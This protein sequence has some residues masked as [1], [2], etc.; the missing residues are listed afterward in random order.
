[1]PTSPTTQEIT[2]SVVADIESKINQ[3]IPLLPKAFVRVIAK[4][5]AGIIVVL[6]KYAGFIFLQIFVATAS[7]KDT[8]VNGQ[9]INPLIF[10]G[11]LIGVGDPLPGIAAE[12]EVD[13]MVITQGGTL[14]AGKTNIIGSLNGVTYSLLTD[15]DLNADIVKGDFKAV[16]DPAGTSGIGS[17]GNLDTGDIVTFATPYGDV[18]SDAI[19]SSRLVD[20]A[21]SESK[22]SYEARVEER[23]GGRP[24]GGAGL[25]YVYWGRKVSG[26]INIYPYTGD[27]GEVDVYAEATPESSGNPDGIPTTAQLILVYDAIQNTEGGLALN[28]PIDSFVNVYGITRSGFTVDVFD[29]TGENIDT[30]KTDISEALTTFLLER[31]PYIDGVTSLPRKQDIKLDDIRSIVNDYATAANGSFSSVTLKFTV[32]GIPF[33]VYTLLEGEKA[34]LTIVNYPTTP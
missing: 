34:K 17:I 7:F 20:G 21:D 5:F 9:I 24:Q 25:D 12:L 30:L 14:T 13:I 3:T 10:W 33:S 11:R 29:L 18:S 4:V 8:T 2:E 16:S 27:P 15:V 28:R 22:E 26:I 23:F 19:V 32:S 6:Y 31:E 1:M